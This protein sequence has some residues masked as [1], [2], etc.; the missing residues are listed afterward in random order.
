MFVKYIFETR[1]HQPREKNIWRVTSPGTRRYYNLSVIYV[2]VQLHNTFFSGNFSSLQ[3]LWYMLITH[4]YWCHY[5]TVNSVQNHSAANAFRTRPAFSLCAL[6]EVWK[7]ILCLVHATEGKHLQPR[8]NKFGTLPR[9]KRVQL[10]GQIHFVDPWRAHS[11]GEPVIMN[12][13]CSNRFW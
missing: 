7:T 5:E 13:N 9:Y 2:C 12:R 1:F 3:T 11:C 4:L 6:M 8:P 10:Q